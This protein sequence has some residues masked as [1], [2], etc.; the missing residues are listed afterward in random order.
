MV[1]D[2]TGTL[3]VGKPVVVNAVLF[4]GVT[5]EELCNMT[6]AIEVSAFIWLVYLYVELDARGLCIMYCA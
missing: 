6:I 3:T 1:F 2:K 4:S 5:L